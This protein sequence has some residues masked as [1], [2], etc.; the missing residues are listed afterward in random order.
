MNTPIKT[1]FMFVLLFTGAIQTMAKDF[2][3]TDYGAKGDGKTNNTKFIQR[4]IDECAGKGGGKVIIPA[5]KFL[6]YMVSLKT[7]VNLYLE[8]GASI[9]AIADGTR[10][11]SLVLIDKVENA[12]VSGLGTLF[13]NGG[14]FTIKEESP[15]RPY[16]IFVRGSKNILIEGVKLR[17]SA[18]WTLRLFDSEH[19]M[20][21]GISIYSHANLN[22]DGIDIDSRDVVVTGC[23][24]DSG[25]DAICL[26]SENP[27]RVTEN[28]S[29][30]N[31]VV[32]SNCN[33]IKM[34]TGSL[35]G[36]KNISIS[37]CVL[38]NASES[39]FHKWQD[40]PTHFISQS[41]TGIAGIALEI[42]DGG[43]MD[44]VSISNISMTGIQTPIFIRLGSRKNPTGSLKNIIISN[45]VAS[46]HSRMTSTI[47]GVPGYKVENVVLRDILLT[48]PGGGTQQDAERKVPENE[49]DYP[50]NRIF[51]WSLPASGLYV[52]HAKNIT[53]DNFQ[54]SHTQPDFRPALVLE[55][56]ERFKATG[57]QLNGEIVKS[58]SVKQTECKNILINQ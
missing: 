30:T 1:V 25:D 20:V 21:R 31:C 15:D 10:Y 43:I 36:F 49:K 55:D 47:A 24:I 39:P 32:S 28:I 9:D 58:S 40:K 33:L 38:R 7:N 12:T 4:A 8:A 57:I 41:I 27:S 44:Q 11:V 46:Y 19:I 13:G 35:G 53:L 2:L 50:E 52:R 5:G 34:G 37:N 18:A 6:S 56:V 42:V 54:I 14:N 29:I 17:Q 22:N 23:I 48:G 51:G 45:I 3:V 26:K 16:I